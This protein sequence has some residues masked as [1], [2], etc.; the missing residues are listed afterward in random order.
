M[1]G[2]AATVNRAAVNAAIALAVRHRDTQRS[3]DKQAG[4]PEAQQEFVY[5]RRD[6]RGIG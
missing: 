5:I 2:R 3:V 4:V 1:K 6:C